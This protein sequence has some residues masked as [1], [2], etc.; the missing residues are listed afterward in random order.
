MIT[1]SVSIWIIAL[2][3]AISVASLLVAAWVYR[4]AKLLVQRSDE[5]MRDMEKQMT[6]VTRGG[7]GIGQRLLTLEQKLR[8]LESK[9][10]D[11]NGGD[12]FAYNQAMQMFRQGA[13]I[14]TVASNCGFSNSEAELM[15]LVQKQLAENARSAH[16]TD[17]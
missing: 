17:A 10:E 7:I 13:D 5:Q 8:S 4:N 11:A 15:A 1:A 14:A 2:P 3:I 9:Q 6:L 16:D 12:H